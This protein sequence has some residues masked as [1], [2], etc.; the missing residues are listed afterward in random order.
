[1][2]FCTHFFNISTWVFKEL[3]HS[4][5]A[6]V[7]ILN[8]SLLW[9]FN[10]VKWHTPGRKCAPSPRVP[11]YLDSMGGGV[12]PYMLTIGMC[13]A[14]TVLRTP[15]GKDSSFGKLN[16]HNLISTFYANSPWGRGCFLLFQKGPASGNIFLYLKYQVKYTSMS[17]LNICDGQI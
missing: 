3:K 5:C 12:L 15:G 14:I 7:R 4:C 16:F 2:V 11:N 13:Y 6:L 10:Q 8:N 9:T 1:M 17:R